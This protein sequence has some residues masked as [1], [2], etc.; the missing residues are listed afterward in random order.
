M[1]S[2]ASEEDIKDVWM[3]WSSFDS[4]ADIY[5]NTSAARV[6]NGDTSMRFNYI[7]DKTTGGGA[8]DRGWSEAWA[9]PSDLWASTNWTITGAKA[10]V[11]YFRGKVTNTEPQPLYLILA[12]GAGNEGMVTYDDESSIQ[13]ETWHPWYIDLN[14][15]NFTTGATPGP[16][17]MTDVNQIWLGIGVRGLIV[18]Q[19]T[20][21]GEGD[22]Y[23][24]DI[25]LY[26]SMCFP[27]QVVD[28]TGDDCITNYRDLDIMGRDWLMYDYNV[29]AVA[30]SG[31]PCG[32][33]RFDN[34]P[35][36]T[37]PD[38]SG[39]GNTGTVIQADWVTAGG[40]P[41]PI[42]G[43]PN[44]DSMHFDADAIGYYDRVVCA[45]RINEGN[46]VG[47]YP[48]ELMPDTFTVACWVK[49]D[50]FDYFEGLVSNGTDYM[51]DVGGFYLYSAGFSPGFPGLRNFGVMIS[52]EE[53][54]K[55]FV[56]TEGNYNTDTW[57]HLA[58]TYDD[59]NMVN[60]Y[61]DGKLVPSGVARY[62]VG[63]RKV[64][65]PTDVGGPIRWMSEDGKYP[66]KFVIG[67]VWYGDDEQ[68]WWYGK[69]TIDDVRVYGYGMPY[70]EI[71]TLA[72]QG[73]VLY[74]DLISPANISDDE[75]RTLKKVNFKDYRVLA[76]LWLK[77]PI[78]WP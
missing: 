14:D 78:L 45:E 1:E 54:H 68:F 7:N 20:G 9:N 56:E 17:D 29:P 49:V 32:W 46:Q 70:G 57:Y 12:D 24:D 31:D 72:E 63:P 3:D 30:I 48:A 33:W 52:T 60:I 65:A 53:S 13:E 37:V 61:V 23:F 67:A 16:V 59:A 18:A 36:A 50:S 2:Y 25:G 8:D 75:P 39:Q 40:Y 74:H 34:H 55:N 41:S 22:V 26:P 4:R 51:M 73:P 21:G 76:D 19:N 5:I 27:E 38:S 69:A 62:G 42:T 77:D 58:A 35:H 15:S 11:L 44:G 64:L 71:A 10:L 43:E 28:I 66:A 6:R 47:D